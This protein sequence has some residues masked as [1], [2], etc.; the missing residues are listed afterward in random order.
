MYLQLY[1]IS[2]GC[3]YVLTDVPSQYYTAEMS[4]AGADDWEEAP[5]MQFPKY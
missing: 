3:T 5:A 4:D 1:K 2:H